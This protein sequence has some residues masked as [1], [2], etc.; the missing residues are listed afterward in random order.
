MQFDT[1]PLRYKVCAFA[2]GMVLLT[3]LFAG[4]VLFPYQ[5]RMTD[6][7]NQLQAE[8]SLVKAAQDFGMIHPEPAK[9]L[10]LIDDKLHV[11]E[12]MLPSEARVSEFLSQSET[13]A[14]ASGAKLVSLKP[15]AAMNKNGYQEWS[16]ELVIH[17][18]FFQTMNF[19]KKIEEGPRFN[20]VSNIV[21]QAKPGQLE[22]KLTISI[23]SFGIPPV[24]ATRLPVAPAK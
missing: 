22:S 14:K 19:V 16:M 11:L 20:S 17:G 12:R 21:M 1:L 4:L 9:Y 7:E 6:I 8:R 24:Q 2:L 5:Q 23:Y 15:G 18:S 10:K 13:A 3:W